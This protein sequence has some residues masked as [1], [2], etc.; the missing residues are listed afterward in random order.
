MREGDRMAHGQA[1]RILRDLRALVGTQTAAAVTDGQL[2]G[3][4]IDDREEAAFA[5]LVHR[6]GGMVL[7]VCRRVLAHAHDAE[8][9]FQ[10][11][12]GTERPSR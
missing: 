7:G 3:R 6:H 11:R 8:D 9:A 2:L 5:A 1:D 4:F 12:C 10:V